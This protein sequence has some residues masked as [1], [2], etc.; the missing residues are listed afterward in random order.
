MRRKRRITTINI[1]V[2]QYLIFALGAMTFIIGI[3]LYNQEIFIAGFIL[4]VTGMIFIFLSY[5]YARMGAKVIGTNCP[6]CYGSGHINIGTGKS[7]REDT[8]TVCQ[9]TGKMY[10]KAK[11]HLMKEK[12]KRKEILE[13]KNESL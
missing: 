6:H 12:D 10:D 8:C 9:G 4:G 13:E 2:I 1:Y 11:M 7:A 5:L 3:Y